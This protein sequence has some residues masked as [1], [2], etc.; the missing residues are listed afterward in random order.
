MTTTINIMKRVRIPAITLLVLLTAMAGMSSAVTVNLR[1]DTTTVT[2]PDGRLVT[3]WGFAEDSSFGAEDGT[4]MVPGPPIDVPVGDTLSI[5]LD[6]NLPEPVS[7]VIPGQLEAGGM[8]PVWNAGKVRSFTHETAP[9]NTV[10]G[11]TNTYTW[12]NL[13]PGTYLYQ[14]GSHPAVQVQ[15]GLYGM[16]KKNAAAG[17]AYSGIGFNSDIAVLYSEIDVNLHD[18][19]ASGAY[20]SG[21]AMTS[22]VNY[23][24]EYFLVNGNPYSAAALPLNGDAVNGGVAVSSTDTVLIRFLNAGIMS[25]NPII[26]GYNVSVIAEDGYAYNSA[27]SQYSVDLPAGK[28]KD[29]LLSAPSAGNIPIYDAAMHLATAPAR[30]ADF[31]HT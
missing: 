22:T 15:M 4:V 14:S 19:V 12:T 27:H 26:H 31:W 18:A 25:H 7:I 30:R 23:M 20:G 13:R 17:E 2:M 5:V 3:M 10:P 29:V 28:T 6:N 8:A 16:A 24:P 9:G 11:T 1:A 21:T